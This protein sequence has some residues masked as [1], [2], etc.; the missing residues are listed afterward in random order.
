MSNV[1]FTIDM[2]RQCV[3]CRKP[4]ATGSGI[5]LKCV[6]RAYGMNSLP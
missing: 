5:C 1:T 3:E 2:N 6:G 4:G